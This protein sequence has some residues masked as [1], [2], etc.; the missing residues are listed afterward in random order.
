MNELI[1]VGVLLAT[2]VGGLLALASRIS[3]A[4]VRSK[5]NRLPEKLSA[6]M[7]EEWLAELGVLPGRTSQLAFA[8]A[9]MLTR[10]HS[11]AIDDESPFAAPARPPITIATFGGWP[12]VVVF[13]T[14]LTAAL[15]YGASF[16]IQPLYRAHTNLLVVAQRV[17]SRFVAAASRVS[18]ENRMRVLKATL[19]SHS[20][21]ERTI[22]EFDLYSS[23]RSL[24]TNEHDNATKAGNPPTPS[25]PRAIDVAIERMRQ[26]VTVDVHE[27]GKA[28]EI[29]YISPDPRKAMLVTERLATLF[30]SA[31]L[32]D[33]DAIRQSAVVFLDAQIKDVRSRLLK[34]IDTTGR[35]SASPFDVEVRTLEHETLKATYR[36]LLIKKEQA[37]LLANMGRQQIGEQFKILDGARLPEAPISPDRRRLTLLG[38][39]IGFC[40]GVAMMVAGREGS[41]RRQQ[42]MLAQS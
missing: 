11:F 39:L 8:I 35:L 15:A 10:R 37:M 28:I 38:A 22:V 34:R 19:L 32:Q 36:G 7:Q 6:R 26:D 9:L 18:L 27:D 33:D 30:I 23:L 1:V 17:P 16:L 31:N 4:L 29:S 14:V 20:R 25:R 3:E 21:L 13:T 42:K 5:A 12:T 40:L 2:I 41:F 24:P